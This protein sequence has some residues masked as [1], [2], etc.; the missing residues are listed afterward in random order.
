VCAD[1]ANLPYSNA[2]EEGFENRIANVL[3]ADLN[4]P[5]QYFWFA[6]H[7]SFFRRTL[8]DGMCDVVISVPAG[9][10]MVAATRPYFAS[11]Y[12]AVTRSSDERSFTS[13]D[14]AWLSDARI[15]LQLV[16]AEGA[17]T[18]PALALARRGLNRHITGYAMWSS[19]DVANPQG[20]IVDAVA[21]G[22]ID[23]ALVWGPFA[24]YFSRPYGDRL[25]LQPIAADPESPGLTFVFP[26]ALGVRKSD[27][28][29]RDRLQAALDRHASEIDAIL[30]DY[31]VPALPVPP[32]A[33]LAA[34]PIA[35]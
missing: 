18:P 34:A 23:L 4:A 22:E 32:T 20:M 15:G 6:E 19:Q 13:F 3:A 31:G 35:P 11:S 28:V 16:G 17:T 10:P 33:A 9:L 30:N 7:R 2:H 5:L 1:P 14:D 29:L 25:R 26:M 21:R 27:T 12:V 8:L 24:G